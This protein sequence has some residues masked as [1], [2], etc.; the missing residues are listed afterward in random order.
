MRTCAARSTAGRGS[1]APPEN[2]ERSS[3]RARRVTDWRSRIISCLVL[4]RETWIKHFASAGGKRSLVPLA[5][6]TQLTHAP[7]RSREVTHR[8]SVRLDERIAR[9]H[10]GGRRFRALREPRRRRQGASR[11]RPPTSGTR[12]KP[13]RVARF[14][15][16]P[17]RRDARGRCAERPSRADADRP[18]SSPMR[19]VTSQAA[20]TKNKKAPW[21]MSTPTPRPRLRGRKSVEQI[22]RRRR[23]WSTSCFARTRTSGRARRPRLWPGCTTKPRIGWCS[24]R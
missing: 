16:L 11:A 12:R 10:H 5:S 15:L 6:R 3:A 24:A 23:S 14:A 2:E 8:T 7:T 17:S 22:Y 4:T 9:R 13:R 20:A 21:A 1:V 19:A 18:P